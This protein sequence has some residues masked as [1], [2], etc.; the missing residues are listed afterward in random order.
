MDML[1]CS[2][3]FFNS[4]DDPMTTSLQGAILCLLAILVVVLGSFAKFFL[5]IRKR[6]KLKEHH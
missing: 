4:P 5:G 1:A 2:V 6:I 3:C